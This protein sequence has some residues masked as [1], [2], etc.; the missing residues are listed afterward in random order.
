MTAAPHPPAGLD[1]G[2]ARVSTTKQSLERQLD[3]LRTVGI[4][5]ERIFTDKRT[6]A[7]V[8]RD[9][10]TALLRYAH[11]GDTIVVHTLDRL[12]RNLREVLNLVHDLAE[13]RI[14]VRSLADPLPI[15]TADDGTGRIAFLLLALFAEMERTFTAER[16]AYARAV[17]AA[18]GRH[19]GR[20]V[21][22]PADRI[23]YARLL[24]AE[25]ASLSAIAAK[26]GIPK[27][28]L[29]RYLNSAEP[30]RLPAP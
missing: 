14:G 13:R 16:A 9:G 20:P 18:A 10:L 30:E 15:N 2:Y 4:P 3:A 8:D 29:H 17:A 25:G 27:T 11:P 5:D 12:G 24:K 1:L 28:S 22:H 6:G 7:T 23:E 26:T 19:V 21:A